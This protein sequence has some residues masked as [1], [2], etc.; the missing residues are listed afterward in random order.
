MNRA[1][2]TAVFGGPNPATGPGP[3]L[4]RLL[5]RSLL[6][7]VLWVVAAE[8][9]LLFAANGIG[10]SLVW[11][12]NGIAVGA[13]LA[14]GPAMILPLAGAVALWHGWRGVGPVESII[15][16]GALVL[17]LVV[18]WCAMRWLY[19]RLNKHNNPLL[20]TGYFH[21]LA[22]FPAAAV[23]AV[24]GVWQFVL[25][26]AA[27]SLSLA[28]MVFVL[29]LSQVFGVLLFART[30]Q[31]LLNTTMHPSYPWRRVLSPQ[32][33]LWV[34]LFLALI[35]LTHS[36]DPIQ[37]GPGAAAS[38][39]FLALVAWAAFVARPLLVHLATAAASIALLAAPPP[40]LAAGAQINAW[41]LDQTVLLICFA[42]VGFMVTALMEQRR[43]LERKLRRVACTDPVTGRINEPGLVQILQQAGPGLALLGVEAVNLRQI[44]DR[45]DFSMARAVENDISLALGMLVPPKSKIAR[46]RDGFFVLCMQKSLLNEA[47]CTR[48]RE[49]LDGKRYTSGS[50]STR[51]E[52]ALGCVDFAETQSVEER[53]AVLVLATQSNRQG[54][55]QGKQPDANPC[56]A[57]A[58]LDQLLWLR[59]QQIECID[60]LRELLRQ[61]HADD[62][63]GLWL[64]C[65][66]IHLARGIMQEEGVEVLLRWTRADST[67]LSPAEFLPLAERHGL[68]TLIDR[69][70]LSQTAAL[71]RSQPGLAPPN[72][73]L[74]VN[75]SGASVSDPA[76]FDFIAE[77]IE[78]SRLPAAQWCFE[79]TE[80]A[81]IAQRPQ[82]VDLFRRLH[83]LGAS[84]SLD[85]FGTGMA[86]FDYLKELDVNIL[87]IDGS[88]V[89]NI[90]SSRVDQ[91]IVQS[92]CQVA[93]TMGLTTVAEFVEF[94]AQKNLL[95]A[96]G[97]DMVQGYGIAR[98]RGL[99]EHLRQGQGAATLVGQ[100]RPS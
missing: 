57:G 53:L 67:P 86:S 9:T 92:I 39:L 58:N 38:Y 4:G 62:H 99:R 40:Q 45:F 41:L 98:P 55:Q 21:L 52:V 46:I 70:V 14:F 12:A 43:A 54:S 34:G 75:L 96:Y 15:G 29:A 51:L 44:E 50:L 81:G 26:P 87:K 85:D 25:D 18:A 32:V 91:Q 47:L 97:V 6:C 24:V 72:W 28:Q 78:T 79:L 16:V 84:T 30:T 77:A 73:R 69:W 56:K 80:T 3:Q 42:A 94:G 23:I 63:I 22:V 19:P 89:R 90:E 2:F 88:F 31:L 37:L 71:L 33:L 93:K 82:A 36:S 8:L 60:T 13:V 64:A 49:A 66:P 95:A 1:L 76:L 83:L 11:P 65:Q 35:A 59:R 27:S 17:A 68:A 10:M 100:T 74:S 20:Q 61:P 5:R 7:A 48:I